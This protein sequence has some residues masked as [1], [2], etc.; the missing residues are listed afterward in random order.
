MKIKDTGEKHQRKTSK[1]L[2]GRNIIK[3]VLTMFEPDMLYLTG[4]FVLPNAAGLEKD[5]SYYIEKGYKM[6]L[7]FQSKSGSQRLN[8]RSHGMFQNRALDDSEEV[9]PATSNLLPLPMLEH[10]P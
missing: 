8:G 2:F 9:L 10:K 1:H 4:V 3:L 7:L 5:E 6:L